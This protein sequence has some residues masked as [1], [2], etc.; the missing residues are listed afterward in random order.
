MPGEGSVKR[1]I[2]A[3]NKRLKATGMALTV[4]GVN[5]SLR[6][7]LPPRPWE[8]NQTR[9]QR[10]V[11]LGIKAISERDVREAELFVRQVSI[12]LNKGTFEWTQLPGIIDPREEVKA[13]GS[14]VG[15][16]IQDFEQE[17]RPRTS[18]TTWRYAYQRLIDTL[19]LDEELTEAVLIDWILD[20]DPDCSTMRRKY[21]AIAK[22]LLDIAGI[23]YRR[24]KSLSKPSANKVLN[25]RDLPEDE[26]IVEVHGAIADPGWRW[27]Y[28]M[29]A[30]YG[31]RPHELFRLDLGHWP[32]VRVLRNT[33]TGE[34]VVP[35]IYAE[36]VE[37]FELSP[38]I[39]LPANLNWQ[40]DQ[41]NWRLGKKIGMGFTRHKLGDPYNLRHCYA[42][43]CLKLG[44]TSD[45]SAALMGHSRQVHEERYRAFIKANVYVEA[46]KRAIARSSS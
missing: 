28:G 43:R 26:E 2:D 18:D 37:L 34:R 23:P 22:G 14:L 40:E 32:D 5:I 20:K 25:P 38:K 36:W 39:N 15:D 19:P 12:S 1:W 3:A 7:T 27:V 46:A 29:L 24:L 45:I 35:A 10:R 6:A 31:L 30:A 33:K 44:M 42:R 4:Y 8:E 11:A 9:R 41:E 21:L 17:R 13:K 16:W